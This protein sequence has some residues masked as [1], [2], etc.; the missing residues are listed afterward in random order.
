MTK[1][2]NVKHKTKKK[3]A[4]SYCVHHTPFRESENQKRQKEVLG[5]VVGVRTQNF[6]G[7]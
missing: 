1:K 7:Y 5:R 6:Q 3:K 2:K 4:R